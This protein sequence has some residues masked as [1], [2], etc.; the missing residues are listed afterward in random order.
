MQP[1]LKKK[2]HLYYQTGII[3]SKSSW[4]TM[5][6][7]PIPKILWNTHYT[8][9]YL[10]SKYVC[11]STNLANQECLQLIY[12]PTF[13]IHKRVISPL[14]IH[15]YLYIY[16]HTHISYYI[17]AGPQ[18]LWSLLPKIS[19]NCKQTGLKILGTKSYSPLKY[20]NHW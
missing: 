3:Q 7:C 15:I 18:L 14:A 11:I 9:Q 19:W 13:G 10:V 16:A 6:F 20:N 12:L 5:E 4:F 1:V 2:L 17:T 8:N